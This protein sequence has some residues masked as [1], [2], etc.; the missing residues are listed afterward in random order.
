MIFN[1]DLVKKRRDRFAGLHPESEFI[2]SFAEEKLLD[3]LQDLQRR[4]FDRILLMGARH[5]DMQTKI[6]SILEVKQI[7][8]LDISDQL[9]NR[10]NARHAVLFNHEQVP[11]QSDSCDLVISHM[12]LHWV[13]NVPALLQHVYRILKKD[14]LFIGHFIGEESLKELKETVIDLA[15]QHQLSMRP[16]VS[17]F[18]TVKDAGM[19]LQKA[20]FHLP[21]ADTEALTVYYQEPYRLFQDIHRMGESQAFHQS[22]NG[23][24]SKAELKKLAMHYQSLFGSKEGSPASFQLVGMHGWKI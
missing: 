3:N 24:S 18:I 7:I 5:S 15:K 21:V 16:R 12:D 14:G 4:Q 17:P 13:N 11:I 20:K 9:L 23:M 19:L 22:S 2:F 8:H 10:L 6:S 1:R